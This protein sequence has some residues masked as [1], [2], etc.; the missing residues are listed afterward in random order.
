[1]AGVDIRPL[2][3]LDVD[4][5]LNPYAAKATRRPEGYS[6]HRM[7]PPWRHSYRRSL[8]VWL[9][10]DHGPALLALP[11]E[12]VWCTSWQQHANTWIAPQLGLPE[13]PYLAFENR[14]DYPDDNT[15]WKTRTV[16][17]RAAGRPFAWVDDE[18]TAEDEEYVRAHHAGPALL[19]H[20]SPRIGLLP[21]D[22]VRLADWAA[23]LGAGAA[24]SGA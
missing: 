9:N 7:R 21:A 20:V 10:H 19:H 12:L 18:I 6:T 24:P 2:L 4:G 17:A 23:Q 1:M 5:P 8:R 14:G 22:F 11:Y 13:L 16:I 15:H 3:L